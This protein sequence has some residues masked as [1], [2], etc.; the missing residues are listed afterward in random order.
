[1]QPGLEGCLPR[2][3]CCWNRGH[4]RKHT[5]R[6]SK[7]HSW[8]LTHTAT[9]GQTDPPRPPSSSLL[10]SVVF[11]GASMRTVCCAVP[12]LPA[13]ASS[14]TAMPS[15]QLCGGSCL[16]HLKADGWARICCHPPGS[17]EAAAPGP[18]HRLRQMDCLSGHPRRGPGGGQAPP[19]GERASS[20]Q[21]SSGCLNRGQASALYF[22]RGAPI[23]TSYSPTTS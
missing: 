23:L 4:Q 11:K 18:G 3:E 5:R 8:A 22:P 7:A 19:G 2:P 15:R 10:A 20:W 12:P 13:H 14:N 16:D 9:Q 6:G 21:P 17:E 1:M